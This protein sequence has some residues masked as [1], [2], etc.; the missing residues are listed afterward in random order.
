MLQVFN[1]YDRLNRVMVGPADTLPPLTPINPVQAF[2]YP[3]DPPRIEK[4]IAEHRKLVETLTAHGVEVVWA[5][6]VAGCDQRD[7]RDI[8]TVVGTKLLVCRVRE[9]IRKCEIGGLDRLLHDLDS[10]SIVLCT[11]GWLEGGD[12]VIDQ[13]TLF[14]GIGKRSDQKGFEFVQSAFGDDFDVVPLPLLAENVLHL[15][16]VFSVVSPGL[17]VAYLET[18]DERSL[19]FLRQRYS[20]LP[21]SVSEQFHLAANILAIDPRS[22]VFDATQNTRVAQEL[23][24][25]GLEVVDVG[26]SE[27]NKIGGS[28]RC[29][30]LPLHRGSR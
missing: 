24:S 29:A 21:I 11:E 8:A 1:E 28:F 25:F 9:G 4:L 3:T 13:E 12:I 14:V 30:T 7:I 20:L 18:F 10:A 15:D 17:A 22:V 23:E 6:N 16:T 2:Y 27:T 26:F 19:K 5:S